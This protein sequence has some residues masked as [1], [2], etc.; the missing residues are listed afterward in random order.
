MALLLIPGVFIMNF[1]CKN[2]DSA[3]AHMAQLKNVFPHVYKQSIPE[4]TNQVI[5]ALCSR[6]T[7]APDMTDGPPG[8]MTDGLPREWAAGLDRLQG[9]IS[10]GVSADAVQDLV[11]SLGGLSVV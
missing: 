6:R 3:S 1:S 5:L 7:H 11:S 2:K 8:E 4:Y 10:Q 9:I